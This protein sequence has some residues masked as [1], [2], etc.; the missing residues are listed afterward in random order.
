[1]WLEQRGGDRQV[2]QGAVG[3]RE[4]LGFDPEGG[5]G[6]EAVPEAG[7]RSFNP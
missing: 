1:M 3:C 6:L 2:L 4:D 7:P 5:G